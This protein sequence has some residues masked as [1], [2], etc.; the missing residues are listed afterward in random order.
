MISIE[1]WKGKIFEAFTQAFNNGNYQMIDELFSPDAVGLDRA[2]PSGAHGPAGAK[3]LVQNFRDAF[4]DIHVQIEY[5]IADG[6]RVASKWAMTGTHQ[7]KFMG[8][9]PTGRK[10][11]LS[12]V[13]IDR[14]ANGK[15]VE[16][17]TFRDD[18]GFIQQ[19][20]AAA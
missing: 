13:S 4:P 18:L 2:R 8:K 10:V 3:E 11:S 7:G 20:E 1:D 6:D 17:N 15:V 5:Q 14:I 9:A 19:I 16:Y 12:A